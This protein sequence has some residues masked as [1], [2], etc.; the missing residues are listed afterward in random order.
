MTMRSHY[1]GYRIDGDRCP[2]HSVAHYSG[3]DTILEADLGAGRALLWR[4]WREDDHSAL[5]EHGR[6]LTSRE[7]VERAVD[8]RVDRHT[9]AGRP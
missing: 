3:G 8:A 7:A 1:R 5:L 2:P 6:A 9:A 4:A